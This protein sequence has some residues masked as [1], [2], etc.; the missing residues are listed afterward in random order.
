MVIIIGVPGNV[1]IN[2]KLRKEGTVMITIRKILVE[3]DPL[4]E[5][6]E[7]FY[8]SISKDQENI[9][10]K[11]H[12]QVIFSNGI[13][14]ALHKRDNFWEGIID[15]PEEE[16]GDLLLIQFEKTLKQSLNLLIKRV[17]KK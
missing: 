12:L 10:T 16:G 3:Y 1:L 7:I 2:V 15:L 9:Y 8:D 11:Y 14:Y 17:N 13:P 5:V 6:H 4:D